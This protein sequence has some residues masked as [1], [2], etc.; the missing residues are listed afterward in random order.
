MDSLLAGLAISPKARAALV[1]QGL[2]QR[3]LLCGVRQ[4]DLT[5]LDLTL[6]EAVAIK[7]RFPSG[8]VGGP[9]HATAAHGSAAAPLVQAAA[10]GGAAAAVGSPGKT[11][12]L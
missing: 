8:A 2:V 7:L 12:R 9:A 5:M 10:S 6:G 3:D 11:V 4:E 1:K